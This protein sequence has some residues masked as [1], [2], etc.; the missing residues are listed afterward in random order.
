[1]SKKWGLLMLFAGMAFAGMA[2]VGV[3]VWAI[4]VN[5]DLSDTKDELSQTEVQLLTTILDLETTTSE[6]TVAKAELADTAAELMTT[7][8]ELALTQKQ[9]LN[10]KAELAI[11]NVGL[12]TAKTE[13]TGMEMELTGLKGEL[14]SAE[15]ELAYAKTELASAQRGSSTLEATLVRTQQQLAVAQETLEG[16]GITLYASRYCFDVDLVD[17]P[18]A[19]NPT[20]NQLMSFLSEDH[21]ETHEY[22]LNEYDCSEFSRDLHNNAEVAGIRS[23]EVHVFFEDTVIGHALNAFITTDYGLV[24]VDCTEAPD[25]IARVEVGKQ[26]RGIEASHARTIDIANDW[27]WDSLR[28]YYYAPN[29]AGGQGVTSDI[30]IFW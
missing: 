22:I 12:A 29:T 26:Y 15:D 19:A 21:T 20:W 13:M 24:Y 6:L 7:D 30:T 5:S 3:L 8:A 2:F 11:A 16:L 17:N 23:A 1:M 27:W 28:Q 14:A 9:L 25:R 10:I 4:S 18:E